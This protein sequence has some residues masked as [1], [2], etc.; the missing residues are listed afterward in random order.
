MQRTILILI[1][2]VT[3][4]VKAQVNLVPN[5]GFEEKDFCQ[6]YISSVPMGVKNWYGA[7]AGTPD[8]LN[9]CAAG[10]ETGVPLN[11]HGFQ[12]AHSGNAYTG[13]ITAERG[14]GGNQTGYSYREYISV[15]L[16]SRMKRD[17]V[18]LLQ[19]Y[20]SAANMAPNTNSLPLFISSIGFYLS[21]DSVHYSG[22]DVIPV[23]P[24]AE[25][26]AT[27]MLN[28]TQNWMKISCYYIANGDEQWLTLGNFRND[29][30]TPFQ[31][32]VLPTPADSNRFF[33]CV[34]YIDDVSITL[35]KPENSLTDTTL[36]FG[37]SIITTSITNYGDSSVW[38]DAVKQDVRSFKQSGTWWLST[39]KSGRFIVADTI[40]LSVVADHG[41][42]TD[43]LV[44]PGKRITLKAANA[45]SYLWN[46]GQTSDTIQAISPGIYWVRRLLSN[47]VVTDTII[48]IPAVSL[49]PLT[50]TSFC[51]PDSITIGY[52]Q[53][54][55]YRFTWLPSL[56]TTSTI[57]TGSDGEY[58]VQ[59]DSA[60]CTTYD[61]MI[62][63]AFNK[64]LIR[65]SADTVVC[66]NDLKRVELDAGP[67]KSYL[68]QPTGETTRTI[69]A[70]EAMI[71]RLTVTDSNSCSASQKVMVDEECI[72]QL[73]FPNAFS[74]NKDGANDE[75]EIR[76]TKR[77]AQTFSMQIYN[78]WGVR[79]FNSNNVYETWDGTM[80]NVSQPEDV[81]VLTASY[82]L[83]GRQHEV[84]MNVTLLR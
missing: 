37:D 12:Y 49:P 33:M 7:S 45:S 17:S 40:R 76:G 50:D 32:S 81:Y 19:A 23:I 79:V 59:I 64:P 18:Y 43:S 57:R 74:P 26:P 62:V 9:A 77:Y 46:T 15:K 8:Y 29:S 68:W 10:L 56:L 39:Y 24:Q 58:V 30:T 83:G 44:C 38:N 1:L 14:A 3:I 65:I 67:F 41:S 61:T 42:R 73:F 5:P 75:Y 80:N 60:G 22:I 71:Y 31:L 27:R 21:P 20:V 55:G 4:T 70:T 78:R 11:N 54:S 36:C 53:T 16:V 25:N 72:T 28:D 69:Y 66:F 82:L 47:C 51:K 48:I 2:F 34:D 13:I 63:E 84:K 6:P 35:F 52:Q